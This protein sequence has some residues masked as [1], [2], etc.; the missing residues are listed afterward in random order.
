MLMVLLIKGVL[1]EGFLGESNAV[2]VN[3]ET[4]D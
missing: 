1:P 4:D 2:V 3:E